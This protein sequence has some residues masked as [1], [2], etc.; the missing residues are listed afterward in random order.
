MNGTDQE[1]WRRVDG[2]LEAALELPAG[3]RAEFLE[4]ACGGDAE[5]RREVESL[6]AHDRADGFLADPASTEARRGK[7]WYFF[8]GNPPGGSTR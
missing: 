6:L 7:G 4:R 2:I 5:L 8:G 1:H 3:E